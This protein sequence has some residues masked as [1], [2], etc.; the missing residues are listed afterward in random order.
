MDPLERPFE[1]PVLYQH[2]PQVCV[3]YLV[4]ANASIRWY[5]E[6][7]EGQTS[8]RIYRAARLISISRTL[9]VEGPMLRVL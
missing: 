6:L 8:Q 3:R 7:G 5:D 1:R 9:Y 4:K 2:L